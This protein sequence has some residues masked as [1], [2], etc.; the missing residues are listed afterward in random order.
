MDKKLVNIEFRSCNFAALFQKDNVQK[1][2]KIIFFTSLF[3]KLLQAV[4]KIL[5]LKL[6]I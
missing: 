2:W 3:Y 1:N 4:I 6:P 5:Y